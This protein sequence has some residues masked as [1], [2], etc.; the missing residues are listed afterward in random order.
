MD[1]QDLR[2]DYQLKIMEYED[3]LRTMEENGVQHFRQEGDGPLANITEHIVAEYRRHIETYAA[4]IAQ[5]DAML[6]V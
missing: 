1:L 6:G 3:Q 4:L 2:S 5:I